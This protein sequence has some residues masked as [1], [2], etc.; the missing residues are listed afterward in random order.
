MDVWLGDLTMGR[1]NLLSLVFVIALI[2]IGMDYLIQILTR[3]R[4]E[5]KR[6]HGRRRCGAGVSL[7]QS[8]DI[9]G[10]H[11]GGGGVSGVDADEF[12]GG[13]GAGA[14]RGGRVAVVPGGGVYADAGAADTVS[15]ERGESVGVAAVSGFIC[16]TRGRGAGG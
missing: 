14:D 16:R 1:L 6:Y 3:Y 9:D 13:G 7:C 11:G 10:V 12:S 2:G 5:K 15:G 4:F 8:A